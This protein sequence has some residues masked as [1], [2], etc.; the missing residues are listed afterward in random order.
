MPVFSKTVEMLDIKGPRDL[1]TALAILL[2][3]CGVRASSILRRLRFPNHTIKDVSFCIT[4]QD[5]FE[6]VQHAGIPDQKRILSNPAVACELELLRR[7][8]MAERIPLRNYSRILS[9]L[10][11]RKSPVP[12]EKAW[13][14][15]E[16]IL[17]LGIKPGPEIGKLLRKTYNMQLSDTITSRRK[18]IQWL[19]EN[20]T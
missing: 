8:C 3:D 9:L 17:K 19:K 14:S 20:Y 4:N 5:R 12:M 10:H 7:K 6:D 18:M 11:N 13:I 2:H 15:G 16:D 1:N